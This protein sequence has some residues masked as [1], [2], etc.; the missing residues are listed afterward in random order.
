MKMR[1][2]SK[3]K[4][5]AC[6][7]GLA[8]PSDPV[9]ALLL[10]DVPRC[11]SGGIFLE[12]RNLQITFDSP[13]QTTSV[14]CNPGRLLKKAIQLSRRKWRPHRVSSLIIPSVPTQEA[15]AA[16]LISRFCSRKA[17]YQYYRLLCFLSS[18]LFE[19]RISFQ[20]PLKS[21]AAFCYLLSWYVASCPILHLHPIM[22]DM[23][24]ELTR[25]SCR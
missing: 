24:A 16:A 19:S 6:S 4:H 18:Y 21:T 17:F 9:D 5:H 12:P 2:L 13:A 14:R 22:S 23:G 15:A 10:E 11:H 25:N 1:I 7:N 3:I 8:P 20:G